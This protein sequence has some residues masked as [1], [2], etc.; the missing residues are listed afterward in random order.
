MMAPLTALVGLTAAG[1]VTGLTM[2]Y[3]LIINAH[4]TEQQGAKVEPQA[5]SANLS[6]AQRLT[7]WNR[8]YSLG[9]ACIPV[10]DMVAVASFVTF[11]QIGGTAP[12]KIRAATLSPN[13]APS[14]F[15]VDTLIYAA[16]G[17]LLFHIPFTVSQT[18]ALIFCSRPFLISRLCPIPTAAGH[19]AGE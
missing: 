1:L 9:A 4:F 10:L 13:T 6:V 3:P 17:M 14:S 18:N 16:S 7:L 5:A 2:A 15:S 19:K 12:I 8:T 11:V